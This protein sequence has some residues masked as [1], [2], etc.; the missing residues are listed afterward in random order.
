MGHGDDS[1]DAEVAPFMRTERTIALSAFQGIQ[2]VISLEAYPLSCHPNK[3]KIKERLIE[4]GRRWAGIA[5]TRHHMHYRGT[6]TTR[7]LHGPSARFTV[8]CRV[9][10][11]RGE[12][13]TKLLD[14][15]EADINL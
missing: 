9:M 15:T 14:W 4:R 11:D 3:E 6:G 5:G 7:S 10:I 12:K 8:N 13:P 1:N 2:K